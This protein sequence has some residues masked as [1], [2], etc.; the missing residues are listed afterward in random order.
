MSHDECPDRSAALLA[1]CEAAGAAVK[2]HRLSVPTPTVESAA[3]ALGVAPGAIMKTLVAEA[4]DGAIVLAIAAGTARVD[5]K[6][7][8]RAAGVPGGRLR[9]VP[10]GRVLA[11]VG[12][13]A[14]AV[15]PVGHDPRPRAVVVDAGVPPL[16]RVH[17]GG[18]A[19]DAMLE[20]SAADIVRLTGAIVTPI[21]EAA[22]GS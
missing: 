20:I 9:M 8:G 11:A 13:G 21:V 2:L 15:P 17:G 7:V 22:A 4:K 12:Y 1:A 6:A 5:V 18:G 14:G 3:A 16:G 19:I 10:A